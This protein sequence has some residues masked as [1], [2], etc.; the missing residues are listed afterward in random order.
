MFFFFTEIILKTKLVQGN[1]EKAVS[2]DV[3][4]DEGPVE[5]LQNVGEFVKCVLETTFR[6]ETKQIQ[7]CEAAAFKDIS[8]LRKTKV[9]VLGQHKWVLILKKQKKND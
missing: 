5:E 4:S 8:C 9:T 7:S 3:I 2:E 6:G 1:D